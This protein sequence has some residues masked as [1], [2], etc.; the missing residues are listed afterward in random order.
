MKVRKQDEKQMPSPR[1]KNPL[2]FET[3]INAY[4]HFKK[5]FRI[6]FC[7]NQWCYCVSIYVCVRYSATTF[8]FIRFFFHF[9]LFY[10]RFLL[11]W[12]NENDSDVFV[13][14]IFFY[15]NIFSHSRIDL[16]PDRIIRFFLWVGKLKNKRIQILNNV[17]FVDNLSTCSPA[18]YLWFSSL[19][20][21]SFPF[22]FCLSL[23]ENI[24][25]FHFFCQLMLIETEET[26]KNVF[27]L[28]YFHSNVLLCQFVVL[29]FSY[30]SGLSTCTMHLLPNQTVH[31]AWKSTIQKSQFF[32]S[33]LLLSLISTIMLMMIHLSVFFF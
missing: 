10:F 4:I 31:I 21:L 2:H 7:F 3:N 12:L 19:F 22:L 6:G 14:L 25:F 9:F 8:R 30:S 13:H 15:F 27:F 5:A 23:S 16:N 32:F 20:F 11:C 18:L 26:K 1:K 29:S 28:S 33:L 17:S 24:F